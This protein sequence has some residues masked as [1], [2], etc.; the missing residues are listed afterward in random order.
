MPFHP[1]PV[2]RPPPKVQSSQ[3][4]TNIKD[5]N[6][7]INFDFKVNSPFQ[8]GVMSETFQR[9]ESFF[10]GTQGIR[11]LVKKENLIHRYLLKQID[12]DKY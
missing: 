5:I 1:S 3:S 6:P 11:D 9:L 12:T 10:S 4:S 7:N 2:H 8:E